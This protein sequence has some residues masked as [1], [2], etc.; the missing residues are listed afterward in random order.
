VGTATW[1]RRRGY[2]DVVAATWLR[3]RGYGDVVTATWLL[4]RGYCDV[5]TATWLRRRGYG[6]VVTAT[7]L[8]Q[9]LTRCLRL[10]LLLTPHSLL[11][12]VVTETLVA[13]A[14][15]T[16]DVA[17][18]KVADVAV[19][20]VIVVVVAVVVVVDTVPVTVVEVVRVVVVA[21]VVDVHG[22][23]PTQVSGQKTRTNSC[24]YLTRFLYLTRCLH[25]T[26]RLHLNP[27]SQ[28]S[29]SFLHLIPCFAHYESYQKMETDSQVVSLS[30]TVYWDEPLEIGRS[31]TSRSVSTLLQLYQ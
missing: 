27:C 21:V 6:D 7:W 25:L 24:L 12:V 17:V 2:G 10:T 4:R 31:W 15:V 16:V 20:L 28:L 5:V 18:V 13:V 11:T 3:R 30:V 1:L 29:T 19:A 26:R 23:S 14:V 8:R 9:Y 22:L